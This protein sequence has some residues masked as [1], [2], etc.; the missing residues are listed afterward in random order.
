MKITPIWIA[1][2]ASWAPAADVPTGFRVHQGRAEILSGAE[3]MAQSPPE[4][5]WSI[6]CDW[7]ESW[8]ADWHHA[9][10]ASTTQAGEWTIVKGEL[11]ACGGTW[12]LEDAYR[13]EGRAVRALR[14]FTWKG[15]ETAP[16]VTL[17]VRFQARSAGAEVLLPGIIYC[18]N[19]SGARSGRVPV[20]TNRPGEE[21]YY[22]E[23]RY[24]M[25]FAYAEMRRGARLAGAALHSIPSP[26]PHANIRD[27]WWSLGV[28]GLGDGTELALLSGPCA[29][30]GKRSSIKVYQQLFA[31]YDNTYLNV[32]PG[33]VI[34]KEFLLEGFPVTRQGD[35]FR[36]PLKTSLDIF[37]PCSVEDMPSFAEILR[38]KWRYAQTRWRE[39]VGLAVFQKH[40]DRK[41]A[42]MG[43]TGQAEAPGYALQILSE[44][45]GDPAAP[46][47]A[48]RSLDFLSGAGFYAGGF[49]NWYDLEKKQ[50]G[51]EELLSQGQAMLAFG[52]AIAAGRRR[53]ADTRLWE[54]FLRRASDLHAAR[55]LQESWRP[56]STNEAVFVAAL[57]KA[58]E[59]FGGETYRRA[60]LKAGAHYAQRHL[61]MRE[62]YWG[63]TLDARCEDKEGAAA[64]FQAFLALYE[65]TRDA[66]HLEWARHACDVML[67][68]TVVWDI[69]MPPGRLRDHRLRTRGWTVVSPQNQHLD[70]WGAISAPDVYRL[71]QLDNREDLKRLAILMYRSCGQM[72]DPGGSQGEQLHHTNYI[73]RNQA[74][75]ILKLRGDYNE[76]WT[77]FWITAHFLTGAARFAEMGVPIWK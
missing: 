28:T 9:A 50:W 40:P 46:G 47:L 12:L 27:Q 51:G 59:L 21:A 61:T 23:H 30:N 7:R 62:P 69:D 19:P 57:V 67:T 66:A 22:E 34:E 6:A 36:R 77:V 2:V 33:A 63:G 18:G 13:P 52:R 43:W 58:H 4:G 1:L 74:F 76:S 54:T 15:K 42:V 10:P 26:A 37:S 45:L 25:P 14:R 68:Y 56:V 72:I 24:P 71:G 44:G 60:A 32:P 11:N 16:K 31:G 20:F 5:L 39:G 38:A 49:H 70:V 55:I 75:D 35:G 53:K 8:P 48:Q 29:T 41:Q 17:S 64:A 3:V 65:M 73:Q